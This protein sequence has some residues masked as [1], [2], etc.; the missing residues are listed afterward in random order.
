MTRQ[1]FWQDEF[2]N[3]PKCNAVRVEYYQ[4]AKASP[5]HWHRWYP[6]RMSVVVVRNCKGKRR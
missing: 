1:R 4:R 6:R 5:D 3:N 2:A